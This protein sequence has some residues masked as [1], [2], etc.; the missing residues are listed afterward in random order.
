MAH[1]MYVTKKH[2]INYTIKLQKNTIAR[3]DLY[4]VLNK[5]VRNLITFS[6]NYAQFLILYV[7]YLTSR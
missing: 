3:Y 6:I 7:I 1:V 5:I 4:R 2:L